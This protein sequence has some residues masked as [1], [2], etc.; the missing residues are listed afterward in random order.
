[1]EGKFLDQRAMERI[2]LRR[3]RARLRCLLE[4]TLGGMLL[5][6][7]WA[8]GWIHPIPGAC[9]LGLLSGKAGYRLGKEEG[10]GG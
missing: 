3:R 10:Y 6:A 8:R 5:A 7:V 1:M 4:L 2:A 9:L